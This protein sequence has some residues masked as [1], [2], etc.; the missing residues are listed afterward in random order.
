MGKSLTIG[1]HIP[2]ISRD[3]PKLPRLFRSIAAQT[4]LPDVVVLSLSETDRADAVRRRYCTRE[5]FPVIITSTPDVAYPGMNRNATLAHASTDVIS[6]FDADDIMLPNRLRCIH[7]AFVKY[8]AKCVVHSYSRRR[9]W[10]DPASE[11]YAQRRDIS[12]SPDQV[13]LGRAVYDMAHGRKSSFLQ[14]SGHHGTASF[15]REVFFGEAP[16]IRYDDR[17]IGEDCRLLHAVLSRYGR[18]DDTIVFLAMPLM[19][20]ETSR[21]QALQEAGKKNHTRRTYR[22]RNGTVKNGKNR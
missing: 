19:H 7:D 16:H 21:S 2:C 10:S 6:F 11:E 18:R 22:P 14:R 5:D 4:L 12:V 13:L 20:Y 15:R 1:V 9:T 3:I 17:P 8:G